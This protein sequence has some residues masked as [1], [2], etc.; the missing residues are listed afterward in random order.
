MAAW[1]ASNLNAPSM[2]L[3]LIHKL[4]ELGIVIDIYGPLGN[5]TVST[6]KS[7]ESKLLEENY[8][9]YLA[10]E[11][12]LCVDYVSEKMYKVMNSYII[13]V[14]YCGAELARFAPPKSYIDANSFESAEKLAEYLKILS[15]KPEEYVKYFWWKQHYKVRTIYQ[16]TFDQ[17]HMCNVCTKLN[18]PNLKYKQQIYT[19][20]Y[21]WFHEDITKQP[22]IKF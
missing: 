4:Q 13:P 22:L 2:R 20:L 5:L 1:F 16:F 17:I 9:F 10:F 11:N 19:N 7:V 8:K 15:E 14:V 12:S 3:N 6:D 18:S 21:S